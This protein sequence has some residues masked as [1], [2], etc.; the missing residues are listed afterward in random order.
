M[1]RETPARFTGRA[2]AE[3]LS[4]RCAASA[5]PQGG[6]LPGPLS[7]I[8]LDMADF[9]SHRSRSAAAEMDAGT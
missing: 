7:V 9:L 5:V 6:R 3:G 8:F 1:M 2:S 4:R